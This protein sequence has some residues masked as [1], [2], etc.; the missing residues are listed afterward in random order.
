MFKKEI[1][2]SKS[3]VASMM[4]IA[5]MAFGVTACGNVTDSVES[6]ASA[7]TAVESVVE[8][9]SEEEVPVAEAAESDASVQAE[10]TTLGEGETSFYFTVVDGDQNETDFEIHTDAATVGEALLALD[11]IAGDEGDYGLYVKTVN[12]IT[13]DYDTDGKYWAFYVD[14]EYAST[15]VDST[16]ITEG[17]AYSFVVE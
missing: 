12:G 8:A 17:A 1:N 16:D 10:V 5:A 7:E 11:L 14:G 9:T 3:F 4:L 6:A 15:G 13:V 2:K